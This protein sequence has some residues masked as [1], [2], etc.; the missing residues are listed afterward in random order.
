MLKA[1][2]HNPTDPNASPAYAALPNPSATHPLRNPDQRFL[3]SEAFTNKFALHISGPMEKVTRRTLKRWSDDAQDHSDL[4]A[5][6]NGF[7]L[8]ESG[9]LSAAIEKTGQA[10]DATYM[11]TAR[12][13]KPYYI[14]LHFH[15][16]YSCLL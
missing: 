7:S 9:E 12:L 16:T 15:P 2:A 13:V 14:E 5:A 6:L 11:S 10:V 8:N 1:P 4:G 3:D